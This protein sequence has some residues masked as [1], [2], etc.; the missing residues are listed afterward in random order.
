MKW[1][2]FAPV[3]TLYLR[4]AEPMEMGADHSA[5]SIFPPPVYTIQ[6]AIRT[7][8]LK[9]NNMNYEDYKEGGCD[10]KIYNTIGKH[11]G[12]CP[13]NV[14]GPLFIEEK[15]MFVPAP[16]T[17]FSE[18]F[19]SVKYTGH[20]P[21]K[22]KLL[23][24]KKVNSPLLCTKVT[25]IYWAKSDNS[26]VKSLGGNWININDICEKEGNEIYVYPNDYFYLKEPH[27]GI[28]L[29]KNRCAREHHL[30]T[31]VHSRLRQGA[32]IL[33]G[34]DKDNVLSD[35]DILK[36]GAEQRFGKLQEYKNELL[37][38]LFSNQSSS[39]GQFL[40]LSTVDGKQCSNND[41]MQCSNN[42]VIA[43]GKI[44]YFGGWDMAK[45]FHKNLKGYYPAGTVFSKKINENCISF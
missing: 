2:T 30:Y 4:G 45:S 40:A 23:I 39:N 34:I 32:K 13:F 33:F 8:Y 29:T 38:K 25:D 15:D 5:S 19:D 3:D 37:D 10:Q 6:G 12:N 35:I 11:N 9:Y 42:S 14:I 24:A 17:W 27:T 36:I 20:N 16:Y 26:E 41:G 21:P 31:F 22:A 28:A 18:P 44:Q 1:F 43:T 7:A